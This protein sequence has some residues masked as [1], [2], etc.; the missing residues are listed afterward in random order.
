M[1]FGIKLLLISLLSFLMIDLG[2]NFL[3]PDGQNGIFELTVGFGAAVLGVFLIIQKI[4]RIGSGLKQVSS[5]LTVGIHFVL[6]LMLFVFGICFIPEVIES[7][8]KRDYQSFF[9]G[10]IIISMI[11]V[12]LHLVFKYSFKVM[13]VRYS[14]KEVVVSNFRKSEKVALDQ[15][16]D[17]YCVFFCL[18]YVA[19]KRDTTFGRKIYFLS[20][21]YETL[22]FIGREPILL[23]DFKR[24]TYMVRKDILD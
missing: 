21:I 22:A 20:S 2:L 24:Q 13:E 3:I 23:K 1:K 15:I 14:D 10:M 19:F 17:V 8:I 11:Y 7:S 6:P 4:T 16:D 18:Q 12:L 5:E 9:E